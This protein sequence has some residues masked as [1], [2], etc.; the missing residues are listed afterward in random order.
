[1]AAMTS[2]DQSEIISFLSTAEAFSDGS[3]SVVRKETH[4]S[5]IFI[6]EKRTFKLKRA[7]K[8]PYL[9]FSTIDLRHRYCLAEVSINK[10][11][12]P[13][14]YI[15]V[16]PVTRE[17]DGSLAI[18]GSGNIIDW[19]VEMNSFDEEMIF[20]NLVG[21]GKIDR[22]VMENLADNIAT[23]HAGAEARTDGGGRTGIAII[24]EGNAKAFAENADGILDKKQINQLIDK[25]ISELDDIS[26]LLE[27]RRGGGCVRFCH[28][29]MHLGNIVL[30]GDTPTLFDAI[31]FNESLNIID[32]LYD[33]A[34]LLMDLEHV[35]RGDLAN[36]AMNR[37]MDITGSSWGLV[38]FPLFLSMRAAIRS[39]VGLTLAGSASDASVVGVLKQNAKEYLQMALDYLS[40]PAPKLIAVGGL[41]GSGKSR[42]AR[43]IAPQIGASPGARVLRSDVLRK[44]IAGVH[45][46]DRLDESGYTAEMTEK[47]YKAVFDEAYA[48]LLSGHSVI[49][50]CVFAEPAQRAA[51]EAVAVDAG[52]EFQGLWLNADPDVMQAR[53][54][55][56]VNNAS[57]ADANVVRKQLKYDIGEIVWDIVD[58]TGSREQT[59]SRCNEILGL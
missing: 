59:D 30:L 37:Y 20:N 39:H 48:V 54:T 32:V 21:E 31:E 10:R 12:A 25:S 27:S 47:T 6:G 44:R 18:G 5:E 36:I 22:F 2:E 35:G 19:L 50:D 49:A 33:L 56:R 9:D 34:F 8:L 15:G 4:I 16:K 24:I 7:V 3:K 42:A 26:S 13:G 51:I 40:P 45:P 1:M 43:T 14:I 46:L 52:V 55:E 58:S 38:T 53:V 29:D 23:F 57:D 17:H 11:T 28:G 41:S